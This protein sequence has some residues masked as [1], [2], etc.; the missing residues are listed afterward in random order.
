MNEKTI[1][2][3]LLLSCLGQHSET[4]YT[5]NNVVVIYSSVMPRI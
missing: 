4:C 3:H 2:E 1:Y 5:F